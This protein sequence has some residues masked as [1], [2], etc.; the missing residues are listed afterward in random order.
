MYEAYIQCK[1]P[2][3]VQLNGVNFVQITSTDLYHHPNWVK[4][5]KD[6]DMT[7]LIASDELDDS[8]GGICGNNAVCLP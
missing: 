7:D 3:T 2:V 8:A 6:L 4:Y 1:F 5:Y